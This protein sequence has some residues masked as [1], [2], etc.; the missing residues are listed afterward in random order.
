[1]QE[2]INAVIVTYN[3]R[4]LLRRCVSS[5]IKSLE[6]TSINSTV[7]V[8]DNNSTD[9]TEKLIIGDF[10]SVKY[11]LNPQNFGL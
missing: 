3:N 11:I 9:G 1:M 10:P 5:V 6:N 8:V 2:T 4:E 7:T